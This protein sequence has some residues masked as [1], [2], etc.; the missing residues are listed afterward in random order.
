[1][2]KQ[3]KDI[4]LKVMRECEAVMGCTHTKSITSKEIL[5]KYLSAMGRKSEVATLKRELDYQYKQMARL[6]NED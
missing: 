4:G 3:A 2:K 5:I 1:M 6:S